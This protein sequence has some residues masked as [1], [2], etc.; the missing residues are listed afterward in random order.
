MN[1]RREVLNGD[2]AREHRVQTG[3]VRVNLTG[4]CPKAS[5]FGHV[6]TV[7]NH[8]QDFALLFNR[9]ASAGVASRTNLHV[10]IP[11]KPREIFLK[12][13]LTKS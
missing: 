1:S 3:I 6:P 13:M 12:F 7:L 5:A 11:A 8:R 2:R 4:F 10:A 9:G